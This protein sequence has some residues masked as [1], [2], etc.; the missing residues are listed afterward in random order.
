METAIRRDMILDVEVVDLLNHQIMMEQKASSKYLAMA[1]WC[2]QRE[3][4]NSATYFY[5]Q[6]EEERAHM[7]KIFKFVN[8]NGGSALSP[9]VDT[10]THEYESLRAVFEA[11]LD[12]EIEVTKSIHHA[13]KT[14]RKVSDFTSEIFLQWFVTEQAEEEEKVRDILDMI[15]LMD[16]MP[17]KMVDERIPTE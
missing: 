8:D 17:L 7:M 10:I 12:A 9:T 11:S 13:F 14:A 1:S 5:N 15:D 16:D 6:A 3:L 2:D 4:R